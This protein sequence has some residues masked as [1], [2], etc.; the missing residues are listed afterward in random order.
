MSGAQQDARTTETGHPP[1]HFPAGTRRVNIAKSPALG[2]V[3]N[4][5]RHPYGVSRWGGQGI[6]V[7]VNEETL[8]Q[9]AGDTDGRF[10]T[11]ESGDELR[12]V[13]QDIGSSIGWHDEPTDITPDLTLMGLLV[14]VVAGV[15]SLRWFS[16]LI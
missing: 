12:S 2:L 10:D 6:A 3:G 15:L 16:R 5:I 1:R 4:R 9:L 11:A 8:R 14:T 7:P 13:Y